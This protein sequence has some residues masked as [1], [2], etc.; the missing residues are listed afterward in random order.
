[1]EL[2]DGDAGVN[3][4]EVVADIGVLAEDLLGE[5]EEVVEIDGVLGAEF[6]LVADGELGEEIVFE[7]CNVDAFV[8]RFG[9]FREDVLGFDFLIGAAHAD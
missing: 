3:F 1:M 5:Q 8:F 6:V 2:I 7:I 4:A 9:N